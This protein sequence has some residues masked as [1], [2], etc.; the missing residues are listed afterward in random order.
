[1]AC[2]K[3][4][5]ALRAVLLACGMVWLGPAGI[6]VA[7]PA[8]ILYGSSPKI[9]S[10]EPSGCTPRRFTMGAAQ[11]VAWGPQARG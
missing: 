7:G 5:R 9:N 6:S 8:G 1:M 4:A 3:K 10:D 11:K 2:F